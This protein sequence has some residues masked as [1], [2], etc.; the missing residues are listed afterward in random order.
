VQPSVPYASDD[1]RA[2]QVARRLIADAGLRPIAAG[3]LGAAH[4]IE[5]LG[6]LLHHVANH[7]YGGD[8]DLFRLGLAVIEASPGPVMRERIA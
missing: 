6:L 4:Q 7:E 3:S 5:Q 8:A 1:E 2:G